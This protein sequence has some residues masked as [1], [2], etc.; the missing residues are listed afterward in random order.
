MTLLLLFQW[1]VR[2]GP[3]R[4]RRR[5]FRY[6]GADA[7]QEVRTSALVLLV[8]MFLVLRKTRHKGSKGSMYVQEVPKQNASIFDWA[9]LSGQ[10]MATHSVSWSQ[11]PSW[12][13]TLK[14]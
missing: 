11:N 14:L 8:F 9:K 5:H 4:R 1:R 12:C 7:I 2:I 10:W 3:R 6:T 13:V